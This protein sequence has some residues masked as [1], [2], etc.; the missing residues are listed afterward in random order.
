MMS[1]IINSKAA[2]PKRKSAEL[3]SISKFVGSYSCCLP[4]LSKIRRNAC[5]NLGQMS[6]LNILCIFKYYRHVLARA[7]KKVWGE[8]HGDICRR[9]FSGFDA[10]N[11][12][13]C[14]DDLVL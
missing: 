3:H 9:H 13:E 7:P 11:I 2:F 5:S 8:N 1:L 4:P 14:L 12:I 6:K 10:F